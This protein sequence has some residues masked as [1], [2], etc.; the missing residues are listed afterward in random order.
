VCDPCL[1][2]SARPLLNL[3]YVRRCVCFDFSNPFDH[4]VR[5]L[6]DRFCVR[7]VLAFEHN[8]FPGISSL[9][10]F[11]IKRNTAEERYPELVSSFFSSAAGEDVDF[12]LTM[13][14][15]EIAHVFRHSDQI[16]FH[17]AEHLDRFAGILQR[18]VGGCGNHHRSRQRYGLHQR[19]RNVS[20]TGRKIDHHVIQLSPFDQAEELAHYLVQHRAA[21]YDRLI[22]RIEKSNRDDFQSESLQRFDAILTNHPWLSAHAEHEWNVGTVDIGV[23]Q[24]DFVAHFCER[25]RQVHRQS[26]LAD[27]ALARPNSD[28]GV[29]TRKRLW[30]RLSGSVWMRHVCAQEI[31]LQAM[32]IK[33]ELRSKCRTLVRLYRWETGS[34]ALGSDAKLGATGE[35]TGAPK[36]PEIQDFP[37]K[38]A[39]AKADDSS[40]ERNPMTRQKSPHT[41]TQQNTIPEQT[42]LEANEEPYEADSP[43]DEELYTRMEGAETGTNRSPREIQTRSER[44]R[45]EPEVEA[46]QGLLSARTLKSQA[47]GITSRAAAEESERQKK[48]VEERPD[49]EAGVKRSPRQ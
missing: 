45:T 17:L 13:R 18:N 30:A 1:N 2:L 40:F 20:G 26:G 14:A 16:Y 19:K 49:A 9:P 23:E 7:R 15:D 24:A 43:S 44:H 47:Q 5:E 31:T 28:D 36:P 34:V 38:S 33:A 35:G 29:D 8:R 3:N 12:V 46:R 39:E 22:A 6:V 41:Q 21:P 11:R 32:K 48:V 25:D 37:I 27:A 42:D 4:P 10:H